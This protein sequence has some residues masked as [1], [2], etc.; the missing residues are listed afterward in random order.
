MLM[1]DAPEYN[2]DHFVDREEEIELVMALARSLT[3]QESLEKRTVLFTGQRGSGKTWLLQHLEDVLENKWGTRAQAVLIDLY[4]WLDVSKPEYFVREVML[5]FASKIRAQAG[6]VS[7]AEKARVPLERWAEWLVHD[8]RQMAVQNC[9]LTLL[10]DSVYESDWDCLELLED[11]LL[12]PLVVE[13]NVLV[14]MAGRGKPFPWR[15]PELWLYSRAQELQHFDKTQVQEM[16]NKV[17][18]GKENARRIYQLSSGY[19]YVAWMLSQRD[20]AEYQGA[21]KSALVYMLPADIADLKDKLDTLCVLRAFDRDRIEDFIDC[22]RS[23]AN[24]LLGYLIEPRLTW[25]EQSMCGYVLDEAIRYVLEQ[26]L[27][28]EEPHRWRELH[29]KAQALYENRSRQYGDGWKVEAQ[30]H[31]DLLKEV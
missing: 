22:D 7:R 17:G 28:M 21:L 3:R 4:K 14:V 16:L 29:E 26:L 2:S 6:Q 25:Y 18:V 1:L 31:A 27:K 12:G 15:L 8:V 24:E 9:F 30:Y 10:L 20:A 23:K 11:A 19:P 5:E 13:P